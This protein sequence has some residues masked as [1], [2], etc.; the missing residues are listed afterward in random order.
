MA[1]HAHLVPVDPC[2]RA[3]VRWGVAAAFAYR[4]LWNQISVI[5]GG[6]SG[7]LGGVWVCVSLSPACRLPPRVRAPAIPTQILPQQV[8]VRKP[9]FQGGDRVCFPALTVVFD[10]ALDPG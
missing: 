8:R 7:T 6:P 10:L 4:A 3:H 5:C 1:D 9:K 2:A